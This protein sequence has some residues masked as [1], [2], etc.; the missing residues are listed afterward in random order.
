MSGWGGFWIALG[1]AFAGC[2]IDNGLCQLAD[3]V[4][5]L[6][7][8]L[9]SAVREIAKDR[10]QVNDGLRHVASAVRGTARKEQP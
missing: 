1:V 7:T 8:A 10:K 3:G 9:H 5:A 4:K 2:A 6:H